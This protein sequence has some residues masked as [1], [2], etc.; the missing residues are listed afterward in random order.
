MRIAPVSSCLTATSVRILVS[1]A[2]IM[3]P[4]ALCSAQKPRLDLVSMQTP[5]KTLLFRVSKAAATLPEVLPSASRM[6]FSVAT[7]LSISSWSVTT[8]FHNVWG[9]YVK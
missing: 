9:G 8:F 1:P 3:L 4:I 7:A 2:V 5:V 6:G